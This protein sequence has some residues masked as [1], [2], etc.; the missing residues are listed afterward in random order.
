MSPWVRIPP[1]PPKPPIP[2]D[3]RSIQASSRGYH[4]PYTCPEQILLKQASCNPRDLLSE[5]PGMKPW[6]GPDEAG[7]ELISSDHSSRMLTISRRP[8]A[9]MILIAPRLVEMSE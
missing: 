8:C 5:A 7:V 6:R 3:A 9:L 1:P 4:P 2:L